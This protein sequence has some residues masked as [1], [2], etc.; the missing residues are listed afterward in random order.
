MP[1]GTD[2][3]ILANRLFVALVGEHNAVLPGIN[4][5]DPALDIPWDKDSPVYKAVDKITIQELVSQFNAMMEGFRGHLEL[6]YEKGRIT[7]AKYAETYVALTQSAMESAVQFALGKDQAF[8]LAVKTQAEAITARNQN[9]VIKLEAM[10]RRATYALTKLKLATEDSTFGVSEL[11]RTGIM[12]GQIELTLQQIDL[13]GEQ[14]EAQRAQTL[15]ARRDD[16]PVAGLLGTQKQLYQQQ[17]I[18]YKEDIKIKAAQ[19]FSGLWSTQ[20]A[21]DEGTLMSD[22]FAPPSLIPGTQQVKPGTEKA[23][24]GVFKAIRITAMGEDDQWNPPPPSP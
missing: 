10:L 23:L 12:P 11:N 22:Y 18:S 7:G 4:L 20:K 3:E 9:E 24:D 21:M 14:A 15:D 5:F 17:I 13:V 16:T 8:W 19:I 6:E 2:S 1:T